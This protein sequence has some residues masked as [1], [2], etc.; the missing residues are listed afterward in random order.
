MVLGGRHSDN[1]DSAAGLDATVV[2]QRL[3]SINCIWVEFENPK[4]IRR[5]EITV[6]SHVKVAGSVGVYSELG[7][8]ELVVVGRPKV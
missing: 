8:K 6:R 5:V 3:I 7:D 4:P 2:I 1:V